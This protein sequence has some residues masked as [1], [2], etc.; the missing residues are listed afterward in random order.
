MRPGV[1]QRTQVV[2]EVPPPPVRPGVSQRTQVVREVPP[3]TDELYNSMLDANTK[4]E[5]EKQQ[6][7]RRLEEQKEREE[8]FQ[9]QLQKCYDDLVIANRQI[10]TLENRPTPQIQPTLTT[11][12]PHSSLSQEFLKLYGAPWNISIYGYIPTSP[13]AL[14]HYLNRDDIL[15]IIDD[16]IQ[17][18]GKKTKGSEP[19]TAFRDSNNV[20]SI[21]TGH[22]NG[23]TELETEFPFFSGKPPQTVKEILDHSLSKINEIIYNNP[24][25]KSVIFLKD[26]RDCVRT[27]LFRNVSSAVKQYIFNGIMEIGR[28]RVEIN[29]SLINFSLIDEESLKHRERKSLEHEAIFCRDTIVKYLKFGS[30]RQESSHE[31][32]SR[33]FNRLRIINGFSYNTVLPYETGINYRDFIQ[34]I[35]ID[36]ITY[37]FGIVWIDKYFTIEYMMN[38]YLENDENE[39][40]INLQT[41]ELSHHK[42]TPVG[43][44]LMINIIAEG[45]MN[46]RDIR[47]VY[48]VNNLFANITKNE[49]TYEL[50]GI[51]VHSGGATGGHYTVFVKDGTEWFWLND[52]IHRK[53]SEREIEKIFTRSSRIN[54]KPLIE[55][56]QPVQLLYRNLG[57][58]VLSTIADITPHRFFTSQAIPARPPKF[59]ISNQ[60]NTCYMNSVIQ[61]LINIPEFNFL[62]QNLDTYNLRFK[63][64]RDYQP[65]NVFVQDGGNTQKLKIKY[66]DWKL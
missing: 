56:E 35:I 27:T 34:R 32:L 24:K 30:G 9:A 17:N 52:S 40:V 54:G 57:D 64:E 2:R 39:Q 13:D 36:P 66:K 21:P 44:Y 42:Y 37:L 28:E 10:R 46:E 59:G 11:P 50:I 61:L 51:I 20:V 19:F 55:R 65:V 18:F 26:T 22:T 16:T 15:I 33:L 45:Y 1:S 49:K 4:L 14:I 31:L 6:L 41:L 63:T 60:G 48:R 5:R 7:T 43:K 8:Q 62:M 12:V 38:I 53:S 47:H 23:F 3:Q 58:S 29:Q 25:C